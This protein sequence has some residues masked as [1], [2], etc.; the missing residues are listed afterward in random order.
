MRIY[1]SK[2]VVCFTSE[3]LEE[4]AEFYQLEK[5]NLKPNNRLRK[6]MDNPKLNRMLDRT[7]A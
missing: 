7:D 1:R 6:A 2:L 3:M 5:A 4:L